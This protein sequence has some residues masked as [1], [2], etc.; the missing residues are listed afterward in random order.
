[1]A[2]DHLGN[3]RVCFADRNGNGRIELQGELPAQPDYTE[4]IQEN[5]YYPFG[6][7]LS[8]PWPP[9]QSKPDNP[10]R[11]NGKEH[12]PDLGLDWYDY[13]ARW[14]DAAV[15]RFTEIDPRA[16]KYVGWSPYNYVL[17]NPIRNMDPL[18]DTV[19]VAVGSEF[20]IYTPGM[21]YT[22]DDEFAKEVIN[23]LNIINISEAGAEV[24]EVLVASKNNYSFVNVV[25]TDRNGNPVEG[26]RFRRTKNGGIIEAGAS[27]DVGTIAHELFHGYQI[28]S[29]LNPA[30]TAG[31]VGAY[32]F[33]DVV[34]LQAGIPYGT[35]FSTNEYGIKY[36]AAHNNLLY[37]GF[38]NADY[39]LANIFFKFSSKNATG[40]YNNVKLTFSIYPKP[41]IAKFLPVFK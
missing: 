21:E 2:R 30:T 8:G 28:E 37:K 11:Y 25:S 13:G 17:G 10:Y 38:N 26:V 12:N 6:L 36:D 40:L 20:I 7:E 24:L 16:E 41:P 15:G 4:I 34:T 3:T 14:Y 23:S 1:M 5:H 32:L 18:G 19:R 29:G 35:S 9:P 27:S 39:I 31:E 22:G 33:Q